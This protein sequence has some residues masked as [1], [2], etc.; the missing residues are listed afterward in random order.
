MG[1]VH[2]NPETKEN[3]SGTI[4][5]FS[6]FLLY[7]SLLGKLDK[8]YYKDRSRQECLPRKGTKRKSKHNSFYTFSEFV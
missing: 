5:F 4:F 6:L 7:L 3:L 8:D 2:C 1:P